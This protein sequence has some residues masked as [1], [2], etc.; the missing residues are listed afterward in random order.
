MTE[1][2]AQRVALYARVSTRD[3]NQD[4]EL[5]LAPMR[6]FAQAQGWAF[7]EFVDHASAA[8]MNGRQAWAGLMGEVRRRRVDLVICWKLDR[9]FRSSL[10][11]HS[12]VAEFA[13]VGVGF[14]CHT[15]EIDTTTAAGRFV[16][17]TLAAVAE[18]ERE[19][20]RERV[21]A[22]MDVAR[23]AGRQIGRPKRA[24]SPRE[25]RLWATVIEALEAGH[26]TRKDAA[27]R[28]R[29]RYA[30]FQREL[31]VQQRDGQAPTKHKER[32]T[33]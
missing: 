14:R 3:K 6:A 7:Q 12:T 27:K 20:I 23:A 30:T 9:C 21:K 32:T 33:P 22:G 19:L 8:D 28:L 4:P 31:V 5:Q 18:M 13:H 2:K 15:Q 29:V 1:L 16:F 24:S 26:I 11:A 10:H 17:A 25:H